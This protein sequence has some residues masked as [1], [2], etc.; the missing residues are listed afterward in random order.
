MAQYV[1]DYWSGN[2]SL[3]DLLRGVLYVWFGRPFG[4]RFGFARRL[5]DALQPVTGGLAMP[6]RRGTVPTGQTT[7]AL[8][9]DL[10]PGELVRIKPHE[11]ILTT[12]DSRNMNRG[13]LFD[14]E[15][16]PFCGGVYRVRSRV[17]RFIDEKTGR[18]KSLKTPAVILEDV[19]CRS[20]FSTCRMFCPR[21]LY[22]WWREIW[23]ERMPTSEG[24]ETARAR[25]ARSP[26]H[27]VADP[28]IGA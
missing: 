5:Y 11:E 20:R 22:S 24:D 19:W 9:L 6:M 14:V 4:R 1:E 21:A 28:I 8:S 18:I 16:V 7:P 23:L 26:L 25:D 3:A 12:L 10:K 13:L 27:D 2:V 15:M 17:E